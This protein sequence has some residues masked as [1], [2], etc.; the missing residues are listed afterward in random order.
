MNSLAYDNEAQFRI[1]A[2]K[3]NEA[4]EVILELSE[5]VKKLEEIVNNLPVNYPNDKKKQ[6][7]FN[8]KTYSYFIVTIIFIIGIFTFPIDL[9]LVKMIIMDII[10]SI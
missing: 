7:F 6:S 3:F 2:N 4:V 9:R 10:S 1:I 8:M 5:K